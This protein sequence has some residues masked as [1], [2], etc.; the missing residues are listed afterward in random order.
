MLGIHHI[1]CS[2]N[3]D[4]CYGVTREQKADI[5][6]E[7]SFVS[8]RDYEVFAEMMSAITGCAY[9]VQQASFIP[10]TNAP[11]IGALVGALI[12]G[13]IGAGIGFAVGG[14]LGAFI[15]GAIGIVGGAI[16]GYFAGKAVKTPPEIPA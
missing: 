6:G 10:P 1:S 13:G 14:P 2:R 9:G 4:E 15:G 7:G 16:A 12:G 11:A 8:P 5:M 3:E